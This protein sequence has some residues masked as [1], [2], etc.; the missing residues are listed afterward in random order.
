MW[1]FIRSLK[2]NLC[3]NLAMSHLRYCGDEE[4]AGV[5]G[6]PY[7]PSPGDVTN[8]N[9]ALLHSSHYLLIIIVTQLLKQSNIIFSSQHHQNPTTMSP[10]LALSNEYVSSSSTSTKERLVRRSMQT[11]MHS[12]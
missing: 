12:V 3:I 8:P 2:Q 9:E 6:R 11:V 1:D 4:E 7:L 10:T 5:V